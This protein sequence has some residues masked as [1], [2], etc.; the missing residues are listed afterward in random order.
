MAGCQWLFCDIIV[1][2]QNTL[3]SV[4]RPLSGE[5][6]AEFVQ[7]PADRTPR[8]SWPRSLCRK[9][10]SR[11][12]SSTRPFDGADA[13]LPLHRRGHHQRDR[14]RPPHQLLLRPH[15]QARRR[16]AQAAR[17][18]HRVD[19]G[20]H[21]GEQVHQP[22]PR[23]RRAL[24]ARA[25]TSASRRPPR[26]LLAYWTDPDREQQALLL[27]D[28]GP[29]D[30]HLPHR[31]RRASTATPGSRTRSARRT[32]R[33][34]P[35]LP[36]IAFKMATGS[37]QDGRHGHAHRLAHAEQAGQP[38]GRPLLRHLPDRHARHHH[39]RPAARAAA[40]RP[41]E[42]LPPARHRARPS[43][44]DQLGQAKILITNFH[45]FQ[46][47]E[48]VA[49]GK[50]TKAILAE[51]EAKP[52]HR[53]ARPDGA[54]RLPRAGHQEEHHRH[55]RRGPPLLPPQA[56]RRGRE[57]HRRRAQ[58]SR[59]ARRRGPR[60]DLRPR[61]RQ[62]QDRRQGHLRPLGHAVLPARLRL[63]RRHALP[64][65]GL[66]LLA[67]RRH[68]VRH[69]QGAPRAGG[70]RLDDRRAADLPRPLAA[71]PRRPAQEGPQDRRRRR[72]AQ[73]ARRSC[74]ARLHS[75]YGNYEKYYRLW[76]QNAEARA[77]RPHAARL[78]R[79]LQQHQRLQAGL[80]LHRRLG[81]ADRRRRP[82]SRPG[83]CPSSATT[84][85]TAAGCTAR[86]RSWSTAS[87]SNPARR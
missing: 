84:T 71:H 9:S 76:E 27:P 39:P 68:R 14:R 37:R 10:S 72:R 29:G 24:A 82:S 28:R 31:G 81:K 51:G 77:K 62:G 16:R 2:S 3:D 58:R 53:D 23:P 65:G 70:R 5:R 32:T 59:A 1:C 38:A 17:L 21:R 7:W 41:G 52:V 50:L 15:R 45:A 64:L 80:R 69:R 54:P 34:T 86:T 6:D 19:Q 48:K 75:L 40:Q 18:R 85:A 26:R 63:P 61:G 56:G 8:T 87:S 43:Y 47:R 25:A 60:L 4:R 33:P 55:Q 67:D 46:L 11:T 12:R 49:A 42:L 30:R 20:P 35:A 44:M 78:H 66:R 79:R 83:N 22:D 57:A 74:K 36:R 73:A 13:P